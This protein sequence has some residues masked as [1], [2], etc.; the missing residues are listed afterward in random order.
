MNVEPIHDRLTAF[1]ARVAR[2]DG[3]DV[4]ALAAPATVPPDGRPTFVLADT[5]PSQGIPLL[6]ARKPLL[7]FIRFK[8]ADERERFRKFLDAMPAGNENREVHP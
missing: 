4:D 5:N 6:D 1:G 8:G 7:H 3:H 2:V